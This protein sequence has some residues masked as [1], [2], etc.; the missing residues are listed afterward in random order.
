MAFCCICK[1]LFIYISIKRPGKEP[2][3]LCLDVSSNLDVVKPKIEVILEKFG[4][5]DILINNAGISYRGEV[6]KS[7]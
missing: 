4:R 2:E 3:V 6:K 7:T 1:F 5:I